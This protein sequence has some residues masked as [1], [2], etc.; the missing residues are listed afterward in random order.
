M[1]VL[2]KNNADQKNSFKKRIVVLIFLDV[3]S[4]FL[5]ESDLLKWFCWTFL[6][7]FCMLKKLKLRVIAQ[8]FIHSLCQNLKSVEMEIWYDCLNM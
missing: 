7:I 2:I 8:N 6:Y 4:V 5:F 1:R 3:L